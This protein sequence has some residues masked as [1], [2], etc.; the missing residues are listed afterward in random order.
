MYNRRRNSTNKE[1]GYVSSA[2]RCEISRNGAGYQIRLA[3]TRKITSSL[4]PVMEIEIG[5]A[6]NGFLQTIP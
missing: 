1:E 3:G 6:F 5:T 4:E 2:L